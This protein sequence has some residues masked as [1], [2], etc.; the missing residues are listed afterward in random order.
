MFYGIVSFCFSQR[1]TPYTVPVHTLPWPPPPYH[2]S[3]ASQ[4]T[5]DSNRNTIYTRIT[6]TRYRLIESKPI[7][8]RILSITIVLLS[9]FVNS[10][11]KKERG[12]KLL[13]Y[14]YNYAPNNRE[15]YSKRKTFN[16]A[17]K[18]P[19]YENNLKL[20]L[21]IK[22]IQYFFTPIKK[23][24]RC[25]YLSLAYT[26]NVVSHL[27]RYGS[28]PIFLLTFTWSVNTRQ[29]YCALDRSSIINIS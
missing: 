11:I 22:D 23:T 25:I 6:D 14:V 2:H 29:I 3:P 27:N 16:R 4:Q 21:I 13:K 9:G 28:W 26:L 20:L 12:V 24:R 18:I 1:I 17:I 19:K 8:Q 5:I 7:V 15:I 10:Y